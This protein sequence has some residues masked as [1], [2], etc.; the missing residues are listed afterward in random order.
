FGKDPSTDGGEGRT[1]DPF[2]IMQWGG[3]K[4]EDGR[5][6]TKALHCTKTNPVCGT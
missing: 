5:E 1:R 6:R 2:S 3:G 4:A